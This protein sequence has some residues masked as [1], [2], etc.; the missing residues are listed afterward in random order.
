MTALTLAPESPEQMLE[1]A[2]AH[3]AGG[4]APRRLL[5]VAIAH[6]DKWAR[7]VEEEN[8]AVLD[9]RASIY[10]GETYAAARDRWEAYR[11][12]LLQELR[13]PDGG[14]A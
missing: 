10:T 8:G 6:R 14:M 12:L 13:A 4:A 3:L 11:V 2:Q 9:G 1:R 5:D 7:L